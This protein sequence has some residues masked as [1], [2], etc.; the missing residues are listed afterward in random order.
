MACSGFGG[1]G[2]SL[3]EKH[4]QNAD[5]NLPGSGGGNTLVY[6]YQVQHSG[7]C[8]FSCAGGTAYFTTTLTQN[9]VTIAGGQDA[10]QNNWDTFVSKQ[11]S[12]GFANK[13]FRVNAGDVIAL[14][15][16][17]QGD[18]GGAKNIS[19]ALSVVG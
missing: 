4:V 11:Y 2:G 18:A 12:Y 9:S 14:Y 10:W 16:Y 6:A 7:M 8:T 3:L 15:L 13:S 17:N 5:F 1:S 19:C